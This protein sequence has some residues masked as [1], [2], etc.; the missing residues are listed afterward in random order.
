[1]YSCPRLSR[2]AGDNVVTADNHGASAAHPSRATV[3]IKTELTRLLLLQKSDPSSFSNVPPFFCSSLL[4]VGFDPP[5]YVKPRPA[6]GF[7]LEYQATPTRWRGNSSSAEQWAQF[8]IGKDEPSLMISRR[9]SLPV[10]WDAP[11]QQSQH[12]VSKAVVPTGD[13]QSKSRASSD[14]STHSSSGRLEYSLKGTVS[15]AFG[16]SAVDGGDAMAAAGG[17]GEEGT[18]D[19]IVSREV[20]RQMAGIEARLG[21]IMERL[22]GVLGTDSP[23]TALRAAAEATAANQR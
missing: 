10:G 7:P 9:G 1:M 23:E 13:Q 12:T 21:S 15:R 3:F 8:S 2:V 14:A 6:A 19:D 4:R 11:M 18:L 16:S 17:G 20:A 22:E 5:R